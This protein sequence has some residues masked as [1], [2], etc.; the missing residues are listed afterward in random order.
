MSQI[1]ALGK[2]FFFIFFLLFL[3]QEKI[4][5]YL[6]SVLAQPAQCTSLAGS[7]ARGRKGRTLAYEHPVHCEAREARD[8]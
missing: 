2:D 4:F 7:M 3:S 6:P 1:W 8:N 5:F